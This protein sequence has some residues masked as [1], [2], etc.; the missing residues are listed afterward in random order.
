MK[1]L[2]IIRGTSGSGKSTLAKLLTKNNVSADD[3]P[4][5]YRNG[6]YQFELREKAHNWC[7]DI[8]KGYVNQS[9][10]VVA[11]HNT[12]TSL[13]YVKP[14]IELGQMYGYQNII[15][16]S[17]GNYGNVHGVPTEILINQ[18]EKYQLY[19]EIKPKYRVK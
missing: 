17:E 11:V 1:I 6:R 5:L 4:G 19:G 13:Q 14:Y 7:Y 18:Q 16:R 9:L 12:F 2:F 3:Y 15:I 10:S 8:V